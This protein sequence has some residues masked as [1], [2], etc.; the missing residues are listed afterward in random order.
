MIVHG[1]SICPETRLPRRKVD[2]PDEDL[3]GLALIEVPHEFDDPVLGHPRSEKATHGEGL[4]EVAGFVED[5]FAVTHRRFDAAE[6][7]V[8][9]KTARGE[10]PAHP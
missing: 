2:T 7:L 5:T 6:G 8:M 4:E 1:R 9:T 3:F 10:F